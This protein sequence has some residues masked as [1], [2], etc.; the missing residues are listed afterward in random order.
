MCGPSALAC[1]ACD[2]PTP[3]F[4]RLVQIGMRKPT[5]VGE[6]LHIFGVLS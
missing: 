1:D 2:A 4:A 5:S 6:V 3:D